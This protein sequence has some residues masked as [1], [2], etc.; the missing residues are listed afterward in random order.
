GHTLRGDT[1]QLAPEL[2]QR[3]TDIVSRL[4][5]TFSWADVEQWVARETQRRLRRLDPQSAEGAAVTDLLGAAE[6]RLEG[7]H[8]ARLADIEE[9]FHLRVLA[10]PALLEW[11]Q[12]PVRAYRLSVDGKGTAEIDATWDTLA[13][14]WGLPRCPA[15]G[16]ILA[17]LWVCE[18]DHLA[19]E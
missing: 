3:V 9:R 13:E 5:A 16:G 11:L 8:S 18:R 2:L 1:N 12:Y 10:R 19:C 17:R 14:A 15:C 4:P 6:Q 7:E